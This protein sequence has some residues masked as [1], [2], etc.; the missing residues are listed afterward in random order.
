MLNALTSRDVEKEESD[1]F[2]PINQ[3]K[4]LNEFLSPEKIYKA[5][6]DELIQVKGIGD[7]LADT[8]IISKLT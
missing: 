5:S 8:I 6:K 3:R 1:K 2:G 7:A 4:L